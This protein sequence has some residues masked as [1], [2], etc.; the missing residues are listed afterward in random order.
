[1][2]YVS[3]SKKFKAQR[4][5]L[6]LALHPLICVLM[7]SVLSIFLA[8]SP[9]DFLRQVLSLTQELDNSAMLFS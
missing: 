9:P 7:R 5:S 3:Y 2:T 4:D 1:M 6:R 8:H